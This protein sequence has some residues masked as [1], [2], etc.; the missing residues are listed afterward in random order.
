MTTDIAAPSDT[1][2]TARAAEAPV[3]RRTSTAIGTYRPGLDGMRGLAML[4]MLGYHGELA[5]CRGAFLALSQFFTLSGF[6]ITGVLL[7]N[8]LRPGGEMTSFWT[9]RIR[10]LMPAAI[11]ALIGIVIFGATVAPRQQADALPGDIFA[12]AT[13]TANWH[14]ILSGQSYLNLFAAPS[15]VQ[16]FWSLAIEEQ[17]YLVLP[18]ALLLLV[19]RTRSP[20]VL[21]G[22]LL[23]AA[24][25]SG[26]WMVG[27]YHHGAGLDRLYY[28]TD[29]RMAELLAGSV[30]AVVISR[31]GLAFTERMRWILAGTG[32]VAFLLTWWGWINVSLTDPVSWEG[33]LPL[34]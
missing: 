20:R 24:L 12:A 3:T 23:A 29:T 6:L 22:S 4:C 31:R 14:F 30:L 10:R 26:V 32:L 33:G 25:A 7:R 34:F 8:H 15:P 17:F 27:L 19:R 16:H 2:D 28:G 18:I 5:W 11:L 21:L 1:T 13:W 9:R